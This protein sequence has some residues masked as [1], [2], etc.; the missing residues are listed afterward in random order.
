MFGLGIFFGQVCVAFGVASSEIKKIF[1]WIFYII[2]SYDIEKNL[3]F[4]YG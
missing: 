2:L 4:D 1:I 3:E